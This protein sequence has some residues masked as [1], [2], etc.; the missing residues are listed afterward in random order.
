MKKKLPPRL[1]LNRETIRQLEQSTLHGAAGCGGLETSTF[2]GG[3]C[4]CAWS[5]QCA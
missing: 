5:D 3:G 4:A 1:I 2:M